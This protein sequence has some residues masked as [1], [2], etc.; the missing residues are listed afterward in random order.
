MKLRGSGFAGGLHS[1]RISADGLDAFP[2]GGDSQS[3]CRARWPRNRRGAGRRAPSVSCAR[4][5]WEAPSAPY[6]ARSARNSNFSMSAGSETASFNST[7]ASASDR[8]SNA[9]PGKDLLWRSRG[10]LTGPPQRPAQRGT[11]GRGTRLP[12][13]PFRVSGWAFADFR[14]A[15]RA[16]ADARALG[17]GRPLAGLLSLLARCRSSIGS[18]ARPRSS[19]IA[20][21]SRRRAEFQVYLGTASGE[22]VATH[23]GFRGGAAI[24]R[25]DAWLPLLAPDVAVW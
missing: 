25:V 18:S 9:T 3:G 14:F 24:S 19:P 6:Q 17:A 4:S 8:A 15:T 23:N 7:T 16:C 20:G 22:T 13:P 1:Y 21:L 10:H 11:Q 2:R 5:W 12:D